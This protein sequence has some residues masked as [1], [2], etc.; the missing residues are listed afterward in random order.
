[1]LSTVR[2]RGL[3]LLTTF[4]TGNPAMHAGSPFMRTTSIGHIA[5][6]VTGGDAVASSAFRQEAISC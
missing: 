5:V 1:L 2:W 6:V 3:A 4:Q